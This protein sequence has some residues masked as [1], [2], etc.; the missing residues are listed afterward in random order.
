MVPDGVRVT[1]P[2]AGTRIAAIVLLAGAVIFLLVSWRDPGY[3]RLRLAGGGAGPAAHRDVVTFAVEAAPFSLIELSVNGRR[4]ASAYVPWNAHEVRFESTALDGGRNVIVARTTLWYAASRR[5]HTAALRLD[6]PR[7]PLASRAHGITERAVPLAPRSRNGRSL[8]LDVREQEVA[9]AFAVQLP[10]TDRAIAAVRAGRIPLTAFVDEVFDAPRFNRKPIAGFFAGV[11]PRFYAVADAVTV[12]A[13]SGYQPLGLED[14]PAFAGDVEIA[15]AVTGPRVRV[16]GS[17]EAGRP[18][19]TRRWGYDVLRLSVDDYRVIDRAPVPLRAEGGTYV[20]ERPFADVRPQ[21]EV[22][23]AFA[24]FSSVDALRRGL[25]LPVFAFV[26]HVVARFLA[27]FHGFVLAVPMFAYLVLSRGRNARFAK[28][29]RRLIV[30]AVAADV[31]DACISAQPDVDGEILLIVPALRALSPS[32]LSI[33]L[34]PAVIGLVLAVLA[35]SVAHL[36]A[37]LRSLVGALVSDGANAVSVAALGF[38]AFAAAGYAA[39]TV[40][41]VPVVYPALIGTALAAGLIAMLVALDWWSIPGRE[42]PRRAFTIATIAFAVAIAVPVS[43]VPFGVWATI[44]ERAGTAF[45]DPLSPLALSAAF[46]R[47]LAPLC[48]LAFGLLLVAGVRP[49]AAALGLDRARFARLVLCCYAVLAGVVVLVPVGFVLAW[50]TYD[51]LRVRDARLTPGRVPGPLV[52]TPRERGFAAIPLA[53]AFVLVEVLL[54]LPS[55]TQHLRE[56]H[57]PFLVLEAA[58]FVAVVIASFVMPAFG[59]AACSEE[60]AGKTGLRKGWSVG[61]WAIACSL[62]AWFLRSDSF[63]TAVAIVILTGLFYAVL[64][65][66]TP[67]PDAVSPRLSFVPDL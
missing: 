61:V 1:P 67:S 38:V 16:A 63:T 8:A 28:V 2:S 30:V 27:F 32:F 21:V 7:P 39:G 47:S 48:P 64:G 44:P 45:A 59:F 19:D 58:G 20:W 42:G 65:R 4:T 57:T 14:L 13:D 53:F 40:A 51:L 49:D 9:A 17:R 55:E 43:L 25:N 60:I 33:F 50:L 36:A 24:P 22:S 31:F 11:R 29:A 41:R 15:N 54:L 56:L 6:N 5:A 26:P 52:A 37:R 3:A 34:V 46:L 35:S 10:R 66:V 18:A 12:S 23:L 62:P